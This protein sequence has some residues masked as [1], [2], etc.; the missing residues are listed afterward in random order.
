ME[1]RKI[2]QMLYGVGYLSVVFLIVAGVYFIWLKPTPTCFDERRNQGETEVDCG[3]PCVPCET[4]TLSPLQASWV[5][6]FSANNPAQQQ[7][8][9]GA[10]KT[11][12]VAE[13]KNPNSDYGAD[14]FS[15]TFDIYD[16]LG[17]K[18]H[19]LTKNS[20]IYSGEIKYLFEANI[21]INSDNIN[22][23]EISFSDINWKSRGEFPKPDIQT[24]EIKT[25]SAKPVNVSGIVVNNNAFGFSK[26][27]IIA[28]LFNKDGFRISASETELNNLKSFEERFFRAIFPS[29]ISLITSEPKPAA[30]NFVRDLTIGSK[31]EDVVSLQK[32]LKE[33]G[34]FEREPTD[35][36]GQITKNALIQYQKKEGI[37]PA[38]GYFGLKT[39]TVVNSSASLQQIYKPNLNEADPNLTKIYVEA[40]R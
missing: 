2:K 18:F 12:I 8:V 35:Y 39:R 19:T 38:S 15:Y 6:H 25:E 24:R 40:I 14:S 37:S 1:R 33:Q 3:G 27:N 11:I 32:F 5:K 28:F 10:S 34:F 23:V 17:K 30:Y 7:A 26:V 31:G 21:N 13:I 22:K 20:F 29:D 36:F 9:Y 4:R 16:S